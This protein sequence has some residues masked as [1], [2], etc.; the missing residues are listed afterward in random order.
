M[1]KRFK[2][3]LNMQT[4]PEKKEI[5]TLFMEEKDHF[6]SKTWRNVKDFVHNCNKA[7]KQRR[8]V[9]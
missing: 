7:K 9:D 3:N 5:L 4:A 8:K 6:D 1:K 2:G